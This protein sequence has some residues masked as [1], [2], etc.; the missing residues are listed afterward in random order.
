MPAISLID[1]ADI[2]SRAGV[3]KAGRLAQIKGSNSHQGGPDFYEQFRD[4]VIAMHKA[5]APRAELVAI[6]QGVSEKIR[7]TNYSLVI[8]GYRK[9]WGNKRLTWFQ[10]PSDVFSMHG[11]DVYINPELGLVIKGQ[12]HVIK[13]YLNG[14]KLSKDRADLMANLMEHRLGRKSPDTR[15]CVLDV[16]NSRLYVGVGSGVAFLPMVEAELAYIAAL[17]PLA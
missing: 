9:W 14:E 15:M 8:A 16:R 17:W 13:L 5:G 6:M 11:M 2:A 4:G 3:Q 12:K 10:P 1:L 7:T